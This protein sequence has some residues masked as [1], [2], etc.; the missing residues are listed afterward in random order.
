MKKGRQK[1]QEPSVATR[2]AARW[3]TLRSEPLSTE[4]SDA[5]RAISTAKFA[6]AVFVLAA[7]FTSYI[8]HV[9]HTQDLLNELQGM[10]REN[11]RLHLQHSQLTGEL[12]AATGPSVIYTRAPGLGLEDGFAY[13]PLITAK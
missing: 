9:Y 5:V 13:A 12:S 11:L 2:R 8:G 6:L 7:G 4:S 1:A 10:R 3:Q